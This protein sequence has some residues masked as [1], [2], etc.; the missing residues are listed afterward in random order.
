VIVKVRGR[1]KK[2][3]RKRLRPR[4]GRRRSISLP[5]L[6]L[7]WEHGG[8]GGRSRRLSLSACSK[9][10]SVVRQRRNIG[11]SYLRTFERSAVVKPFIGRFDPP[12]APSKLRLRRENSILVGQCFKPW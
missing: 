12:S 1:S 6:K 7:H 11:Q 3:K 5:G 2:N 9:R 4:G 10:Y 8:A